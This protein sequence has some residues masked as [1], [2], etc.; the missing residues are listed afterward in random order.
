[1]PKH[2]IPRKSTNIDMTAMC[3]VAFLLLT[4][5]MLATKFKP[6]EAVEITTP[7]SVSSKQVP[8]KDVM[9]ISLDKTGKVYLQLDNPNSKRDVIQGLNTSYSLGLDETHFKAFVNSPSVGV[10][11]SE[12]KSLLSLDAESMKEHPQNGIPCDSVKNELIDWIKAGLFAYQGK[13]LNILIKADNATPY[14]SL[15]NVILSIKAL[16]LSLLLFL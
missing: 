15:K 14:P 12:L 2:K 4:F 13:K 9:L 1:M 16:S 7:N 3:D 10:P 11:L 8:E 6:A 5:F